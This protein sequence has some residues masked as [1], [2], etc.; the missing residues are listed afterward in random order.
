MYTSIQFVIS[1]LVKTSLPSIFSAMVHS[2]AVYSVAQ[3]YTFFNFLDKHI[4]ISKDYK[5]TDIASLNLTLN[6]FLFFME[7]LLTLFQSKNLKFYSRLL[8]PIPIPDSCYTFGPISYI[9][10]PSLITVYFTFYW[11]Y[12]FSLC[13]HILGH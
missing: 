2:V 1:H 6:F 9:F 8:G 7:H 13:T 10:L 4:L 12:R 11:L 5:E 3:T